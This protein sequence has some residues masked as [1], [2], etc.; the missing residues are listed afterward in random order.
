MPIPDIWARESKIGLAAAMS[1]R[2]N[3]ALFFGGEVRY[4]TTCDGLGQNP[5][6]GRALYAGPT[7]YL[8]IAKG[9]ALSGAWDIQITG[10]GANGGSLDLTHFER[11]QAKLR[12]N[13]NF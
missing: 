12:F 5:F 7:F 13:A 10:R 2:V 8:Q 9:M 1:A 3:T 4:L 11:Q 6:S